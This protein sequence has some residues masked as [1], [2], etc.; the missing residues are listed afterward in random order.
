MNQTENNKQ[1][2]DHTLILYTNLL[3]ENNFSFS[4]LQKDL[5]AEYFSFAAIGKSVLHSFACSV[6]TISY[7]QAQLQIKTKCFNR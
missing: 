2:I 1:A 4:T 7:W 5:L 6:T 3:K